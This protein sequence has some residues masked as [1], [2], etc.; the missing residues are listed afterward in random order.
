M[1]TVNVR[2]ISNSYLKLAIHTGILNLLDPLNTSTLLFREEEGK[3]KKE[4]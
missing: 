1:R 3:N 2:G 4:V